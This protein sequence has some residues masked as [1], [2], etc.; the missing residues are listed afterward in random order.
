LRLGTLIRMVK[1][2]G[3]D[4]QAILAANVPPFSAVDDEGGEQ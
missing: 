4:A 2:A 1:E 3:H